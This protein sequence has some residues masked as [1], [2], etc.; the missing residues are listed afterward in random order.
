METEQ[1]QKEQMEVAQMRF[2]IIAPLVQ[3][4]YTDDS[5]AAYCRRVALTP[6]R[7]PDGRVFSYKPKTV[8]KWYQLYEKGGMEALV[9][10]TRCDK[11][12]TRVIPEEAEREIRRLRKEYPRLNA[13]QVREKLVQEE[14]DYSD[15]LVIPIVRKA[16]KICLWQPRNYR[17]NFLSA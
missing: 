13:T 16:A 1:M 6:Q 17:N 7:L 8:A 9:P 14:A 3:G 4:T 10:R 11:G 2:G 15:V 12:G 5:M